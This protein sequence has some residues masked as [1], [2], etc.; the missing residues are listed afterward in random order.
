MLRFV[1]VC[2]TNDP[3]DVRLLKTIVWKDFKI[4]C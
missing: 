4:Q 2:V 3:L 1:D